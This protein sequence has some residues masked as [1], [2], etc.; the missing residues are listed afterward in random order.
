M[1]KG[2][3]KLM[4][5]QIRVNIQEY[6]NSQSQKVFS[7]HEVC[8]I[9]NSIRDE[10]DDRK[11]KGLVI[12]GKTEAGKITLNQRIADIA[13]ARLGTKSIRADDVRLYKRSFAAEYTD[14]T[15]RCAWG[16]KEVRERLGFDPETGE[17][18]Q[19]EAI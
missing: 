7:I 17:E 6:M 19:E 4:Q 12:N 9:A 13:N 1:H 8:A 16:F 5:G 3:E 2:E 11:A 18:L 14:R 15:G 10:F